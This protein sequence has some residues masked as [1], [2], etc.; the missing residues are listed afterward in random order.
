MQRFTQGFLGYA[1]ALAICLAAIGLFLFV[2]PTGEPHVPRIDYTI[3]LKNAA[4][5][6]SYDVLAPP[7]P[8]KDWIPTSSRLVNDK[9]TVTWRLGFATAAR[10]HAM[11]AQSDEQPAGEFA[12]RMANTEKAAGTEQIGGVTWERRFREDKNQRTL[13][14]VTPEATVVITGQADWPEL[15]TLAAALKPAPA[16]PSP[17]PAPTS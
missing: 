1:V 11:L 15:A 13:V 10:S 12:N 8:P 7:V 16:A 17:T 3:D 9:G 14:R 2:T 4:R 6:A 5:T